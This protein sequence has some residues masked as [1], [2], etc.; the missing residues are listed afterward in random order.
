MHGAFTDL[1]GQYVQVETQ[2]GDSARWTDE[3]VLEYADQSW[4]RVRKDNG[5]VM[6]FPVVHIRYVKVRL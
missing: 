6:C 5:E 3:G 4:V 2:I 1:I